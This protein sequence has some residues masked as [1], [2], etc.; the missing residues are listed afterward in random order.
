[1]CFSF[2]QNNILY[3]EKFL[4]PLRI[5]MKHYFNLRKFITVTY[6]SQIADLN[7][8]I[9]VALFWREAEAD[10]LAPSVAY[11]LYVLLRLPKAITD[12]W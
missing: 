10:V 2:R 12:R 9:R 8:R 1:M 7:F 5:F 4:R 11:K 3:S 6:H